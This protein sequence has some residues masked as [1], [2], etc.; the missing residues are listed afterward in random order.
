MWDANSMW[1]AF[2]AKFR[3]WVLMVKDVGELSSSSFGGLVHALGIQETC[4]PAYHVLVI[5]Q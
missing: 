2:N 3:V 1:D 4:I 5:T